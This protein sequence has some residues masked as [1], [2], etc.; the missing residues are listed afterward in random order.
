MA[1]DQLCDQLPISFLIIVCLSLSYKRE[2]L[3]TFYPI[4]LALSDE[5]IFPDLVNRASWKAR[6]VN[7]NF[8]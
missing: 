3:T 5:Q 6:S 1:C 7:C 4:A 2:K 8:Y